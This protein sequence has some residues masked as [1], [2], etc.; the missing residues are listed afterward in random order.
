LVLGLLILVPA[1]GFYLFGHFNS[2][3]YALTYGGF[4]AAVA[5][6]LSAGLLRRLVRNPKRLATATAALA[7]VIFAGNAAL[8]ARGWPRVRK[9]GQRSLSAA[10]IR[11]HDAYYHHLAAFLRASHQPGRVRLLSSWNS[12]DGLRVVQT[13]LPEYASDVAQAVAEVPRLP[14]TFA[15]LS[16]LRLMTPDQIRR[17]GRP[18]YLILR[19]DED[20]AY[21]RSLFPG[22]WQA[23]PISPRHRLYRLTGG[24]R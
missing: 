6:A 10:E 4:L 5:A 24:G 17:E 13:L 12:T 15:S 11:D 7:L 16:W 20:P 23:V 14:P 1:A 22:G 9:I 8:F 18:T 19:T 2:P 3:G 21:H